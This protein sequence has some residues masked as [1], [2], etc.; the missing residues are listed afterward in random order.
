MFPESLKLSTTSNAAVL[1]ASPRKQAINMRI[2]QFNW[3]REWKSRV[4]P[5][6]DHHLVQW[7]LDFGMKVFDSQWTPGDPPYLYGR[8]DGGRIVPGKLSWYQPRGRCHWIAFFSM[9]VGV[10]NHPDLDWRFVSGDAHTVP[11][12]FEDENP[13]LVMDILLFDSLTASESIELTQQKLACAVDHVE[14]AQLKQLYSLF[15]THK[16]PAI[17]RAARSR[18]I[19]AVS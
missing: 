17:Q 9:A 11:V 8:P 19:I 3:R 5:I 7:S 15:V 16:V 4:A 12:G 1:T 10:M 13:R 2:A 6:L 14:A 18:A